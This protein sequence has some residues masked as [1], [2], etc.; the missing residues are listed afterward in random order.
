MRGNINMKNNETTLLYEK[1]INSVKNHLQNIEYLIEPLIN[2]TYND[3]IKHEREKIKNLIIQ[4]T[5]D[6]N[7]SAD[8]IQP[9]IDIIN[10]NKEMR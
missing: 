7:I 3:G 5:I 8:K 1:E 9:I 6:N 10:D 4:F 2:K